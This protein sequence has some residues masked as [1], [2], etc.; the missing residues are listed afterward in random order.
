MHLQTCLNKL[1]NWA[2]TNG[3]KFSTSKTV[4]MHF[5]RL[6]KLN[7][8]P[9]LLLNDTP[10]PVVEEVTFL[11][12]IFDRKLSFLPHLR[13]LKNKCMKALNLIRVVAH[14]SWGADQ[15]TVLHLYKSLVRSK[16]DYRRIIYGSARN[17]YLRMLDPV[18]NHALHLCL[19]AYRTSPS[20]SLCVFANE[21]PLYIR[22]RKLSIEYCLKLSSCTQN[23][24]YGSVFD[25]NL[26]GSL[27]GK[28]IEFHH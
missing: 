14:T 7:P 28:Q 15:H 26:K 22:R 19:G 18:Q 10:I 2:D 3:F 11:S 25:L 6:R 8:E 13:Y 5:C 16:L 4:C 27:T 20:P 24:T 17:S 23:P 1:Q 21:P 9:E 12:L